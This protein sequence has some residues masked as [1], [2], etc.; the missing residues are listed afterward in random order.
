MT[1]IQSDWE[2]PTLDPSKKNKVEQLGKSRDRRK[3]LVG[4]LVILAAV[5]YLVISGTLTGARYF[6]T[7]EEI[8]TDPAFV[9]ETV[10]VSGAVIG[11]TIEFDEENLVIEFTISHIPNEF[12]DLATALHESVADPDASRIRVRVENEPMPD[13]LQHEA[14]AILTGVM[15]EN[16]V[17][18]ANELLLKCPSRFEEGGP[19]L[20]HASDGA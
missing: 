14:Q 18:Q 20:A 11:E 1:H 13:L 3:F 12:D 5:M 4:G 9:G 8:A 19:D 6:V 16:G 2:K 15:D 10:R 17:F 7:V